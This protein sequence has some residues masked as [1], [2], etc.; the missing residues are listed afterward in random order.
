[1]K[2][3]LFFAVLAAVFTIPAFGD[4]VCGVYY[5]AYPDGYGIY[6][7]CTSSSSG[8]CY[9]CG[10]TQTGDS[11]SSDA[12]CR[13]ERMYPDVQRTRLETS[14]TCNRPAVLRHNNLL[15]LKGSEL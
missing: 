15:S 10:D 14:E 12:P 9:N 8:V 4:V 11:C 6:T 7:F 2:K 5:N 13:P 1:M 3:A